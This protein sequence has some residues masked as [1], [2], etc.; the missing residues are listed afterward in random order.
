MRSMSLDDSAYPPQ[1]SLTKNRRAW[2]SA[3]SSVSS[4]SAPYSDRNAAWA[5]TLSSGTTDPGVGARRSAARIEATAEP[6]TVRG[7]PRIHA[8]PEPARARE[9]QQHQQRPQQRRRDH[10]AAE[11]EEPAI[12]TPVAIQRVHRLVEIGLAQ[13]RS[14]PRG[15]VD[16]AARVKS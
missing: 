8:G 14:Q 4:S 13:F 11:R 16:I 6:K 1:R 9:I 5:A 10:D 7:H 12:A 2:G 15:A 3:H